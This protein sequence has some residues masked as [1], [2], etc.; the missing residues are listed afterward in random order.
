MAKSHLKKDTRRDEI[1][2]ALRLNPLLTDRELAEQF[3]VSKATIRLDRQMLGIPQMRERMETVVKKETHHGNSDKDTFRIV[4][5]ESDS[6]IKLAMS[7]TPVMVDE[8]GFV[9]AEKMY[10]RALEA[11]RMTLGH[12][13][14]PT[15]VGNIKYKKP[16]KAGTELTV[17]S[18]IVRM[19]GERKYIYVIFYEGDAEVFRVKFIDIEKA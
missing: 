6:H 3:K 2:K 15:Q 18:R 12:P 10:G 13:L 7:V 17:D 1:I 11:A 5:R 4:S 19:R 9:P 14:A 16:V 8:T